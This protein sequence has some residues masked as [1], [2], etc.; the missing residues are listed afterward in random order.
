MHS[1][2]V[3]ILLLT[4]WFQP[5]PQFKGLPLAQ[6][7]IARGHDVEVLTG[8]PNYPGG[9]VYPGYRVQAWQRETMD[10]VRVTR[11]AL[12]PS[13]DRS[14]LR[15]ILNYASFA[16]SSAMLALTMRRPDVVYVYCPPMT[17]AAGAV[18]L[19]LIRGVPYVIDIQDLWPDTL[20]STGMVSNGMLL[21]LVGIWSALAMNCAGQLVVLSRGFKTRL[22]TRGVRRPI[23]VI[24]NWAPP[25]VVALAQDLPPRPHDSAT[26]NVVFAGNMGKAQALDTVIEAAQRL[27]HEAPVV[28][29]ILVGSGVEVDRLR[30]ASAA[31]N[32]DNVV[33]LPQRRIDEMGSIFADADALLVH[34]RDDPLFAVTIPSKTQAYLA[35]G[36][37]I[38]MGVRG[39]AATLVE[40]AGAGLI[41][42]PEDVDSLVAATKALL[43]MTPAAREDMGNAGAA[44]YRE[45]MGFDKGVDALAEVLTAAASGG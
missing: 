18:T 36:R 33:F 32:T 30:A 11:A 15:R 2:T 17:A 43:A 27:K 45:Q 13:H 5:E 44:Y 31:L 3:R 28:R 10:G 1:M 40:A 23:T 7:L 25:E 39:D 21:R 20:A 42:A 35:V 8:F 41:F 6:A 4:Q 24:P 19:R 12:Y 9:T 14:A 22:A 29:F 38:L 34:L 37:P 26:F 16:L